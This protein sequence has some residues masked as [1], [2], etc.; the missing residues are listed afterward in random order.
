MEW[1]LFSTDAELPPLA[2]SQVDSSVSFS[3]VGCYQRVTHRAFTDRHYPNQIDIDLEKC[4]W[5]A[6][7]RGSVNFAMEDAPDTPGVSQCWIG[8]SGNPGND[9]SLGTGQFL[10][11]DDSECI[12]SPWVW[13]YNGVNYPY[14]GAFKRMA[15]Y[16][17]AFDAGLRQWPPVG[18][19][20]GD[21][22]AV[23]DSEAP[24]WHVFHFV[25]LSQSCEI[26]LN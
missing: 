3:Y 1:R 17:W 21:S 6:V 20:I 10:Q 19:D 15:V 26:L 8:D 7:M 14:N 22:T 5:G 16:T 11:V 25:S 18:V 2:S 24:L 12:G 9:G 23:S 4:M 13:T